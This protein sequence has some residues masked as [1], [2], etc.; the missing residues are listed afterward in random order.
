[1]AFSER[2]NDAAAVRVA[3][4]ASHQAFIHKPINTAR[5]A[6]A[7]AV[8]L[9]RKF[10]HTHLAAGLSKLSQ[11]IEVAQAEPDLI[12]EVHRQ[13]AH[14]R[15]VRADERLPGVH[16]MLIRDRLGD[17]TSEECGDVGLVLNILLHVQSV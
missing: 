13:L 1:M 3:I 10:A 8:R 6:R 5:H 14:Q 4:G 9:G 15:G 17:E 2:D 16:S 12:D 11:D 7:R